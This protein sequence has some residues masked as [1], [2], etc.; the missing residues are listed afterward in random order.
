MN[1]RLVGI[2]GPMKGIVVPLPIPLVQLGRDGSNHIKLEDLLV[3]RQHCLLRF[4]D[5]IWIVEDLSSANGTFVNGERIM[6]RALV[7]G[8]HLSIGDSAFLFLGGETEGPDRVSIDEEGQ[9][10]LATIRLPVAETGGRSTATP[11]ITAE[12]SVQLLTRIG[13][14][15]NSWRS[16]N[17]LQR[18]LLE[19][20]MSLLPPER[21]AIL[22]LDPGTET[23]VASYGWERGIGGT[24]PADIR[25]SRT[26]IRMVMDDKCAFAGAPGSDP[27]LDGAA[28]IRSTRIASIAAAPLL[29][30]GRPLGLIYLETSDPSC[31]FGQAEVTLLAAI[32]GM[33]SQPLESA[34]R[35]ER[36]DS[37]VR[38][39]RSDL[40]QT[41]NM[42]GD[43]PKMRKIYDSILRA[44][45]SDATVLL[46]GESGTG[47]ELA[48]RAIHANSPRR[49]EAWV[50]VNCAAIAENLLESELFGHE[51]GAF[52][53]AISQKRGK[54]ELADG[55]TLFLDEIGELPA[56]SQS[57]LLRALQEKEL[58]RVG[59]SRP[60]KV[61][62][63][64]VAATNRDLAELVEQGKFRDDL[65]YR[66]NVVALRM[67]ALRDRE[68]DIL[69]LADLFLE[70]FARKAGRLIR[71]FSSA[72]RAALLQ[73]TWPGNVR[74]LQNTVERAV[75]LGQSDWIE[76]EDLPDEIAGVI[77]A[78][79]M[80]ATGY[81]SGVLQS[82]RQL[83][84]SAMEAAS[85]NYTQAAARLGINVKY[86]H[87][88]LRAYGLKANRE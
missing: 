86:L 87:R 13:L 21:A 39:L 50:A 15:L 34:L 64:L 46:L 81:H 29:I 80:A 6:A 61:D 36:L 31:L 77:P 14:S 33:A 69:V 41:L 40:G 44:A 2:Q 85:G 16:L 76:F 67:P 38:R 88:L 78:G 60:I 22:L 8:D 7:A 19:S 49:K 56:P 83:L 32:A 1:D 10:L 27:R 53:G 24:E 9:D 75:V 68:K 23:P 35:I 55:G 57:K 58:E 42:T 73:Y 18:Q 52:T 54:L 71:G 82:K 48:A 28:S 20:I 65:Y 25:V 47:K 43:S 30:A 37:E 62:F 59:G 3:S 66:L 84:T 45:P 63:R 79:I 26:L 12:Q 74:E 70:R 17:G 11:L 72:A 51:R 5:S 4:Q